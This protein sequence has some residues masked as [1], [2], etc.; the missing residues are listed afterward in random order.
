[1]IAHPRQILDEQGNP[2]QRPQIGFVAVSQRAGQQRFGHLLGLPG[3][4]FRFRPGGSLAGQ[5]RLTPSRPRL[6]PAISHLTG[7][8][9]AAGDLG[10]G[11][12]GGE[13]FGGL[14]A[15]FFHFGVISRLAHAS[16]YNQS[17]A[18]VTL[19]CESQ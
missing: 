4:Q 13:E 18:N 1:M 7:D 9:Q 11:M 6:F 2:R 3:R 16:Y 19:I 15:A 10:R 12:F 17:L 14:V 5:G 8:A